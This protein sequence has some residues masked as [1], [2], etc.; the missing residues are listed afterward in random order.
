M[1]RVQ[2]EPFRVEARSSAIDENVL[3]VSLSRKMGIR[4]EKTPINRDFLLATFL[5]KA[6]S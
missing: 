5:S 3:N 4:K 2:N 1:H 6:T